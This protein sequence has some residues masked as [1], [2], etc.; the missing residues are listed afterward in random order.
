M[1]E[2]VVKFLRSWKRR[3]C[4]MGPD[5][6]FRIKNDMNMRNIQPLAIIIASFKLG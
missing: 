1:P 5:N 2:S 3:P 6:C 4:Q